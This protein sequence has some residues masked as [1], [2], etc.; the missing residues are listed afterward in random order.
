MKKIF[1]HSLEM[2]K[3]LEKCPGERDWRTGFISCDSYAMAAAI[4]ED[5]ITEV[6]KIG[7]SVELSGKLTRG[8]MVMDWTDKLKKENKTFVMKN[9][10]LGKFRALMMAALQ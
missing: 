4:D 2:S 8:M 1:A 6:T 9:C 7:V 5:F 3:Y 10:D